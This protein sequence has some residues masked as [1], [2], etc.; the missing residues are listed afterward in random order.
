[1]KREGRRQRGRRDRKAAIS[2]Q[3][4]CPSARVAGLCFRETHGQSGILKARVFVSARDKGG[5]RETDN[6]RGKMQKD[7]SDL[8]GFRENEALF[9]LPSQRA[10][11]RSGSPNLFSVRPC[12]SSVGPLCSCS[13]HLNS[14]ICLCLTIL[15]T[16]KQFP[17]RITPPR[18]AKR[19]H[20]PIPSYF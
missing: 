12:F 15:I 13:P 4:L 1:M 17:C 6:N 2:S 10:S 9:H 18:S 3:R 19:E 8:R 5:R 16:V 20:N 11:P 7:K 14:V